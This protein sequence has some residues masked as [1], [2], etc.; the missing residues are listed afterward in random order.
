M[1]KKQFKTESKRLLD[2]MINSIYTHKEIFLRELIS[3]AS[4]A[5]D[6]LLFRALTDETVTV[7]REDCR[8]RISAD[9]DTRIL[10]VEDNGIGMTAEELEKNLG[11]I[12]KSGSNEF[13]NENDQPEDIT[14]IG[15]FGVGFYSAFMV[16]DDVRVVSRAWGSD[17]AY[18]WHSKG[19]DGFT[20]TECGKDSFGTTVILHIKEDTEDEDYSRFLQSYTISELV[21]KYSDYIRYPIVTDEE[22]T[23]KDEDGNDQKV[24]EEK[25]L[26]SMIPLWKRPKGEVTDEEYADFYKQRFYDYEAPLKTVSYRTEGTATFSALLFIPSHAP[27]NFYSKEYERGLKLYSNGVLIMDSCK[28]L[29]PDWFA[30]VK[31]IVDSEDVSLNISREMLQHDSQLKLIARNIEKKIKSELEKMLENEREEYEKF[32]K[33]FGLQIKFGIQSDFGMHAEDLKD[34]LIFRTSGS[35]GYTTL[36]EYVSRLGEDDKTIY[37]ACGETVDK[38]ASLP[39]IDALRD[40]GKEILYCTEYVDEFALKTLREYEGR[41]FVNACTVSN[42]LTD[43][44]KAADESFNKENSA[45]ID[46]IKKALEGD[47]EDVRFTHRLKNHPVT[48]SSE[49]EIS[50]EM[51]K[52]LNSMPGAPEDERVKA[53]TVLEINADHAVAAK[54][55]SANDADP[56][57]VGDYAKALYALAR[58]AGGL[59]V[60]NPAKTAE[61]ICELL[62]K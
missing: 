41:S 59:S 43:E 20:V 18:E 14:V 54:L 29:L 37:Y 16:A 46:A 61:L 12:A 53:K 21:R 49:G 57:L 48:L 9:K 19:A 3:N 25:T 50:L 28:D 27:Y 22:T 13:K 31:G 5:E 56:E 30:F 10:T 17:T 24:I 47:V 40:K 44:E 15:Q 8:I 62:G 35:D 6:K 23:E 60:E 7:K 36:A 26:N 42:D 52:V 38:I 2:L 55:R 39:Q 34:L 58:L 11:T 32:F 4:D 33:A 51:E 45:L 1:S